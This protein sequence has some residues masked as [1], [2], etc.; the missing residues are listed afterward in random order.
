MGCNFRFEKVYEACIWGK[1]MEGLRLCTVTHEG[2][3]H[4]IHILMC[5]NLKLTGRSLYHCRLLGIERK[6]SEG[7]DALWKDNL[8]ELKAC[9][10]AVLLL[11]L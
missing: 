4:S 10:A 6:A 1:A 3:L 11:L 7:P 5:I 2:S 8:E 9:L